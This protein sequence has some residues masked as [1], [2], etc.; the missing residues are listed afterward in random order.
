MLFGHKDRPQFT[1]LLTAVWAVPTLSLLK[2]NAAVCCS[3]PAVRVFMEPYL[4]SPF[5]EGM[6]LGQ[7]MNRP[8]TLADIAEF[9]CWGCAIFLS[10]PAGYENTFLND[11]VLE[12]C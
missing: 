10:S 5:L 6:L 9:P 7:G 8:V 2:N 11:T 12:S 3:V 4:P 1:T